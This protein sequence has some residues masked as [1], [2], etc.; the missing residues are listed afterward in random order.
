[1]PPSQSAAQKKHRTRTAV[2]RNIEGSE[3]TIKARCHRVSYW[4]QRAEQGIGDVSSAGGI[5]ECRWRRSF[6]VIYGGA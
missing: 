2:E 5:V 1:M 4:W 3:P 6:S